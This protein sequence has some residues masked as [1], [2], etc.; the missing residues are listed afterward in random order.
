MTSLSLRRSLSE[1]VHSGEE[2]YRGDHLI[3]DNTL[4]HHF[5]FQFLFTY[6]FVIEQH[7][8]QRF[9][10]VEILELSVLQVLFKYIDENLLR[11]I[12]QELLLSLVLLKHVQETL[13]VLF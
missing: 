1:L 6:C 8:Q 9:Q 11:I 12:L 4:R 13:H 7:L 10:Q 5:S 3:C 2:Y